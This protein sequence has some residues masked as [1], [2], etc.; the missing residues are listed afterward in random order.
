M[1][2]PDLIKDT[3]MSI[4]FLGNHGK[5]LKRISELFEK[6]NYSVSHFFTQESA[7][8]AQKLS[9]DAVIYHIDGKLSDQDTENIK[10]LKKH[11][12]IVPVIVISGDTSKE[13]ETAV[14]RQGVMYYFTEPFEETQ[15][16]KIIKSGSSL[17]R[18]KL[19]L[20]NAV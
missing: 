20:Y 12:D 13:T 15:L 6:E 16:V 7:D 3:K 9:C 18:K 1:N 10:I 17:Y 11:N 4:V 2:N 19:E 8:Y 14:R 5:V